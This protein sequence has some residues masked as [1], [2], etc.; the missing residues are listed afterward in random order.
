MFPFDAL[1]FELLKR[2]GDL[3]K[4]YAPRDLPY[5]AQQ[6][7]ELPLDEPRLPQ[8]TPLG[9]LAGQATPFFHSEEKFIVTTLCFLYIIVLRVWRWCRCTTA[10]HYAD[11]EQTEDDQEQDGGEDRIAP[12]FVIQLMA[13]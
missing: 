4:K 7:P 8:K 10:S 6:A 2:V 9:H 11:Q 5:G 3:A 13:Q 1:V 12:T